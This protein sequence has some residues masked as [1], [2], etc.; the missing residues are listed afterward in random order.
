MKLKIS[1]IIKYLI[2]SDI[3][4]WS[5][6]GLVNPIFAIFIVDKIEGGTPFVIGIAVAIYWIIKSASVIPISILLDKLPGEKDDYF[7]MV[8]GLLVASVVP[9]G[10]VFAK[11]PSHIYLLQAIYGF[12][13]A[14]SV[15]G[16]RAIFTRHIDK[17]KEATEWSVDDASYGIG[18]GIA[19]AVSGWTVSKFGFNPVFIG[20][21]VMGIAGVILLFFLKNEIKGVFDK[22]MRINIKG[23]LGEETKK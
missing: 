18:I 7:F 15:S 10:Y 20:A 14:V 13:I 21:G 19:G 3:A 11:L 1:R 5:A 2:L 9:F 22:G 16:W 8:I 6:W 12:G 17:G 23:I 4:F